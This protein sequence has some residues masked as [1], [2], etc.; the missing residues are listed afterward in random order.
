MFNREVA[1]RFKDFHG[2]SLFLKEYSESPAFNLGNCWENL[3]E[4]S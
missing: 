1:K 2:S 3:A 4:S